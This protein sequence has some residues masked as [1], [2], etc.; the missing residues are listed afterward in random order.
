MI[1]VKRRASIAIIIA[2]FLFFLFPF[3]VEYARAEVRPTEEENA[4]SLAAEEAKKLETSL[5]TPNLQV[6]IPGLD[7][8]KSVVYGTGKNGCDKGFVCAN[9]IE[10]Y[11][12]GVYKFAASAGVTFAIVLIMVGGAQYAVGSA[13][14]S[15][16]AG[17]KRITNAVIGLVLVLS[18]H[19]IL[20][21]VNP[22][23]ATLGALKLEVVKH[24]DDTSVDTLFGGTSIH[25]SIAEGKLKELTP[26]KYLL[27]N[28]TQGIHEDIWADFP[29]VARS[30]YDKTS[31]CVDRN[32]WSVS[33]VG[34]CE[35]RGEGQKLKIA[36]GGRSQERQAELY[37]DM[38]LREKNGVGCSAVVCN[39]FP[40][41]SSGPVE[42]YESGKWRVKQNVLEEH[43]EDGN[44]N[45]DEGLRKYL[46]DWATSYG[47]TTC[48]HNT[49]FTV[50]VWPESSGGKISFVSQHMLLE[51]T[52]KEEG[53]CRLTT[54][55][56][57]FE[58]QGNTVS[59]AID[60]NWEIGTMK[61]ADGTIFNYGKDCPWK[62]NF[63]TAQCITARQAGVQLEAQS[64]DLSD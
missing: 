50:D 24:E 16:E 54:E 21:F 3:P 39:P 12:N 13:A 34:T 51:Q 62:V 32:W 22:D 63:K 18:V 14:G 57:H 23:I 20:T 56:W 36:S 26:N 8:S 55:P 49:G 6:P 19:A 60:C 46:A 30:Y 1:A 59:G 33:A 58:Y 44:L 64:D 2:M 45:T 11:L 52:M 38:C 9:T 15:I 10:R 42:E 47:Q 27:T 4:A 35:K 29:Q 25:P 5:L 40:R 37:F 48:P 17:K 28:G 61:K 43:D 31:K 41:D 7:L 53:W